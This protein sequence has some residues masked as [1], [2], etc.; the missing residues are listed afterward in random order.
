MHLPVLFLS[1]F[2][3][4]IKTNSAFIWLL[5]VCQLKKRDLILQCWNVVCPNSSEW[6]CCFYFDL[7]RYIMMKTHHTFAVFTLVCPPK[8]WSTPPI[9]NIYIPP[10]MCWTQKTQ[11]SLWAASFWCAR[12][13]VGVD[14]MRV[15]LTFFGCLIQFCYF[16]YQKGLYLQ[17]THIGS[18]TEKQKF[19]SFKWWVWFC[20]FH[21]CDVFEFLHGVN[22]QK[23]RRSRL[24]NAM[25]LS[26]IF[27][28][29]MHG[30]QQCV[31]FVSPTQ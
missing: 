25:T 27:Y 19:L 6:A 11:M 7:V 12:C 16:L 22:P 24:Q 14:T 28:F 26:D 1:D 30:P 17:I 15:Q 8:I 21:T 13:K 5:I 20:S 18:P 3:L 23:K 9:L 4:L 29:L 31:N 10:H 2:L